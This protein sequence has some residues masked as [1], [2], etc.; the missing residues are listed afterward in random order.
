M[1]RVLFTSNLARHVECPTGEYTGGSIREVLES[2]FV[3]QPRLR[4][5]IVDEQGRL[6]QH[7]IAF[8]DGQPIRDRLRLSDVTNEQ[9]E[10]CVMQAL[11]GG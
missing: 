10:V 9:S 5:Y 1:P 7:V 4:G 8:V 3:A 11:S 6:R 2:V